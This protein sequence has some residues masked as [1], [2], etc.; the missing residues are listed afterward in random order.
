MSTIFISHSSHDNVAASELAQQLTEWGYASIFLD[1]DPEDGIPAGRDWEQELYHQLRTCGAVLVLC[2]AHSMA[3]YWCFAEITHA[4]A[5]GKHIFPLKVAACDVHSI[6]TDLQVLDLTA[7]A[8]DAYQRLEGALRNALGEGFPWPSSRPPYPGLAA[9]QEQDAAIFFGREEELREGL[10]ALER[11][12]RYGAGRAL[13]ILGASGSGK[14]SLM[15]AGLLPRLRRASEQWLIVGPIRPLDRPWRE[16]AIAL[17]RAFVDSGHSNS[18]LPTAAATESA[19][20]RGWRQLQSE[21]ERAASG[22]IPSVEPLLAMLRDLRLAAGGETTKVLVVIDQA[23][24]LLHHATDTSQQ[25]FGPLLQT[26]LDAPASPLRVLATLRTDLLTEFQHHATTRELKFDA[27]RIGPMTAEGLVEVIAGPAQVAG[28]DLEDGLIDKLLADAD[29]DNALPLLAFALRELYE[30][31]GSDRRLTV[32]EYRQDLG[33]LGGSVAKAAEMALAAELLD[34]P[35]LQLFRDAMLAMVQLTEAGRYARRPL[36]HSD[37]PP[38]VQPVIDRFIAARLLTERRLVER[39]QPVL[40]STERRLD[41]RRLAENGATTSDNATAARVVEVAH[42]ILFLSWDRL[43]AWLDEDRELLLWRKRLDTARR[44]WRRTNRHQ[45]Q[46]LVGPALA[47]GTRWLEQRGSQLEAGER[48]FLE[49]SVQQAATKRRRRMTAIAAG[50]ALLSMIAIGGLALWQRAED[51][52]ARAEDAARVAVASDYLNIDPTRASQVLLEVQDPANAPFAVARMRQALGQRLAEYQ[53]SGHRGPVA[54]TAFSADGSR[55]VTA[56][57]DQTV[58][59]WTLGGGAHFIELAGQTQIPTAVHFSPD[60]KRVLT[61]A[62]EGSLRIWTTQ[63]DWADAASSAPLTLENPALCHRATFGPLGERVLAVAS[64]GTARVWHLNDGFEPVALGGSGSGSSSFGSAEH[65]ILDATFGPEGKRIVSVGQDGGVASWSAVGESPPHWIVAAGHPLAKARFNPLGNRLLTLDHTGRAEVLRL[66]GLTE[67]LDLGQIGPQ[68]LL[69]F[70]RL[71]SKL[72]TVGEAGDIRWWHLEDETEPWFISA[73]DALDAATNDDPIERATV[74]PHGDRSLLISES[75]KAHLWT[76]SGSGTS[77]VESLAGHGGAISSVAFDATGDLLATA[78][79]DRSARI[80]RLAKSRVTTT[81]RGH[82]EPLITAL[83]S[84]DGNQILTASLDGTARLWPAGDAIG[85]AP[86]VLEHGQRLISAA[87]NQAGD[88]VLTASED[89]V[90]IWATNGSEEPLVISAQDAG[91]EAVAFAPDGLSIATASW[92]GVVQLWFLDKLDSMNPIATP[93]ELGRQDSALMALAFAPQSQW[94]ATTSQDGSVSLW[95]LAGGKSLKLLGHEGAVEKVAFSHDGGRLVTSAKDDTA[96]VWTIDGSREPIILRGH[97]HAVRFA[98]FSP[99]GQWVVTASDDDTVRV[100]QLG[101]PIEPQASNGQTLSWH[102]DDVT[103]A[104]FSRDGRYVVS[105]SKDGSALVWR[106]DGSGEPLV[107]WHR[108]EA[109]AAFR[110]TAADFSPDGT[111]VVTASLDGTARVWLINADVLRQRI[112]D[113]V[114]GCIES[115]FRRNYLGETQD[116]AE[117]A[118]TECEARSSINS[119]PRGT[120]SRPRT[121]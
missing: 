56:S 30:H 82:Q 85:E 5:L 118:F 50:I 63:S 57:W 76:W 101:A 37:I 25:R 70:S 1:F 91:F 20:Q 45:G 92:D 72:L 74:G 3:S 2:S 42:E 38:A 54:A 113:T 39:R 14:S 107:L 6:L 12:R 43:R 44:E 33:G 103:M 23:E 77:S 36:P 22:A 69:R 10:E 79:Q 112:A 48:E 19:R 67:G 17:A 24:E 119:A 110:V 53:L 26:A 66:D 58:R 90:R 35:E 73:P 86:I 49:N 111:Q 81:L 4:K 52:R 64:D 59:I 15:R 34:S 31:F 80:W 68:R 47:E 9:L 102:R 41:G 100:W 121:H 32:A 99:D 97:Q 11:L 78:S 94:L 27:L 61:V 120:S 83:F 106:L 65:F 55:L 98:D 105:A 75:G 116:E 21:L 18:P 95:P 46:L 28:V 16:L 88:R 51:Q 7:D 29:T 108:D 104:R 114:R 60:G 87:L 84:S 93:L 115:E 40:D 13:L 8:Q 62:D 71:G 96:R 109:G 89:S 117:Q